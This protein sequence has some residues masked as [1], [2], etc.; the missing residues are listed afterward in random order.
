[1]IMTDDTCAYAGCDADAQLAVTWIGNDHTNVYCGQHDPRDD[2]T[3]SGYVDEAEELQ[4][5][6]T[7]S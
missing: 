2:D 7:Q 4:T 6:D 3:A 5:E 1:M